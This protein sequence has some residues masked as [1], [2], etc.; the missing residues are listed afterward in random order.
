MS[1]S[2]LVL[3]AL[4]CWAAHVSD[5]AAHSGP[6]FPIVSDRQLGKYVVSVWTDPDSTDDG[7]AAGRF[8]VVVATKDGK[9][10]AGT[11]VSISARADETS[12][13]AQT[14]RVT[15]AG[16]D[17]R[18]YYGAVVFGHEGG[19]HVDV[20]IEGPLGSATMPS[21][22]DAT[23]DLRPSPLTAALYVVPFALIGLL[24]IRMLLK[25]S[26]SSSE[27]SRVGAGAEGLGLR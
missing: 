14:T 16:S 24:W 10:P 6:P 17:G 12:D 18:T 23:Y 8:W 2:A 15:E 27:S 13:E 25:R 3:F 11:H 19:Y 21:H 5:L 4:A 1:R 9:V 7:T 20:G 26:R 22:V